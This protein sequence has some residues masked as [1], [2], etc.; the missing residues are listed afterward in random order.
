MSR[1]RRKIVLRAVVVV[2]VAAARVVNTVVVAAGD[3]GSATDLDDLLISNAFPGAGSAR[4]FLL[5]AHTNPTVS[6]NPQRMFM[7]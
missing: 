4:S 6:A 3:A 2:V 7:L 1:V 5:V